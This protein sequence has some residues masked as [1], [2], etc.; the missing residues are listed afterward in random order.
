MNNLINGMC[1]GNFYGIQKTP[2]AVTSRQVIKKN[3]THKKHI[4]NCD[5]GQRVAE[6]VKQWLKVR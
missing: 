3:N 6:I 2:G 4:A 1:K 5:K